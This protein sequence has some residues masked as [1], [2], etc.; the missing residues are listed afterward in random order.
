MALRTDLT[1]HQVA[2]ILNRNFASFDNA[3]LSGTDFPLGTWNDGSLGMPDFAV[4]LSRSTFS[5]EMRSAA[6]THLANP[7]MYESLEMAAEDGA[8]Y[9]QR[10]DLQSLLEHGGGN[11]T[12]DEFARLADDAALGR[13]NTAQGR[14]A[15]GNAFRNLR[16][17]DLDAAFKWLGQRSNSYAWMVSAALLEGGM[18]RQAVGVDAFAAVADRLAL[19]LGRTQQ[20]EAAIR[21]AYLHVR[22]EDNVAVIDWLRNRSPSY[23]WMHDAALGSS[24]N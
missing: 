8:R 19:G 11:L 14:A 16:S 23:Y 18:P 12:V 10:A 21:Q 22:N 1:L 24:T 5:D 2:D 4:V 6:L 7:D 3:T 20:S 17:S 15:I 13:G 9:V